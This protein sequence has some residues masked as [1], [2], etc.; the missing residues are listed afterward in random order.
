MIDHIIT[1]ANI[2]TQNPAQPRVEALAIIGE[3]IVAA[4][5]N[6]EI[7]ALKSSKTLHTNANSRLIIPG[8][9]DAHLHW[10]GYSRMLQAVD[11]VDVPSKDE[12]VRR[13][14]EKAK[15]TPAG[16]WIYGLGWRK[17]IWD[18]TS[19]P[20]AAELDAATSDHPVYLVSR[21][22]HA[23]WANTAAFKLAAIP[24]DVT[25]PAGGGFVRNAAGKPSGVLLEK[26]AMRMISNHMPSETVDVL[27][28]WMLNAQDAALQMG[29]TGFHDFDNPICM[30]A[31]QLLRGRGRLNMRVVKQIN[32]DWIENAYELGIRSGFGDDWIRFGGLKIFAD[33]ALGPQTAAMVEPYEGS[34][35]NYGIT[36][37][38]KETM[39]ELV[40]KASAHGL[41]CTIHAIGDR[42]VHDVLDVFETVRGEEA[43]NKIPRTLRRHRIEHVQVTLPEDVGRLA[44][45]D[46][47]A[48]MQT[49]HATSDLEMADRYWGNRAAYSYATRKQLNA[50]AM[51]VLGSDAPLDNIDPLAGIHAAVTR[52]RA[53]GAPGP[54]G[55]YPE[56]K[57]TL[58]EAMA[59]YTTG[60]AYAAS[61]EDRLGR[62]APG[63]LADLVMLDRDIF[64]VDPMEILETGVLGTM[65]GGRWRFQEF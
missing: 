15:A 64:T 35:D 17:D 9:T 43:A 32:V 21:S 18:D 27:A 4:G 58:E 13:V 28:D 25:D 65:V 19:F 38:D 26:P 14:A 16:E 41:L 60:P 55:W 40:S 24:D 62:L 22:G 20:T 54:Q 12:A 6:A 51:L 46:V 30:D 34:T 36:I 45:L 33:G 59:A 52:R 11:L 23:A 37:T 1:N 48:S 29:M 57:L 42:A 7:E 39:M 5:T 47:I 31:L 56:E 53:D 10:H 50:G 8:L 61:M 49:I 44:E 63:Y 3:Y 2:Y